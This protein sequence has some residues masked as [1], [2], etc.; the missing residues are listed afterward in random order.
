VSRAQPTEAV[1]PVTLDL[2]YPKNQQRL[3]LDF[4]SAAPMYTA[5][6][7]PQFSSS[8]HNPMSHPRTDREQALRDELVDMARNGSR[9][10][11]QLAPLFEAQRNFNAAG[12]ASI[13]TLLRLLAL[14][15]LVACLPATP[16]AY[17]GVGICAAFLIAAIV[18]LNRT[19]R[20]TYI[21]LQMLKGV[22]E[23][24]ALRDYTNRYSG[25]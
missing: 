16:L 18:R 19:H 10:T 6:K 11:R 17:L 20:E 3:S 13:L 7:Q 5:L 22:S 21:Q 12:R 1:H 8:P 4:Q 25:S 23:A 14:G 2:P 15:G 9:E 24:D